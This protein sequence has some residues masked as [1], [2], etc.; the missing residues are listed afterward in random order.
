VSRATHYDVL[1]VPRTAAPGEVRQAY[2]ARARLLHPDRLQG[3]PPAEAA[4]MARAMQDVNEAWRVLRMPATRA[5][6]DARLAGRTNEAR[7]NGASAA[8]ARP[9]GARPAGWGMDPDVDLD[10]TP[11]HQRPEGIVDPGGSL[12]R[13]LPWM[14]A[15]VVLGA[16]FVFT[17]FAGGAGE[18]P[19]R[20]SSDLV[21]R[22]VQS[23]QGVGVVEVPCSAA[24]EGR[25]DLIVNRQSQCPRD[26]VVRPVP[27]EGTWVCLRPVTEVR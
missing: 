18:D 20:S 16:I 22:C 25:V 11:Y 21:G 2:L 10:P 5:A 26:T 9:S 6:Y 3:L 27:G 14:V 17:A 13:S 7:P 23:Q 15:L 8:R 1:G 19:R 12:V 4:R 24:N